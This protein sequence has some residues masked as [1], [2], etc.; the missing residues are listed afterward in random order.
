MIHDLTLECAT[1][2]RVE[3]I[4]Q[5]CVLRVEFMLHKEIHF[6]NLILL[7]CLQLFLLFS[8]L[9]TSNCTLKCIF[10][11]GRVLKYS[12]SVLYKMILKKN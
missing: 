5:A 1:V 7:W 6:S 3:S 4:C 11:T 12:L 8:L 10:P 2:L 9:Q